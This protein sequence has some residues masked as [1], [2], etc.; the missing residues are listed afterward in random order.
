MLLITIDTLRADHVGCYGDRRVQTP[1]MDALASSGVRFESAFSQV[2]ITLP[3]HVAILTGTY[4][5]WNGV[6][7][8]TS[9]PLNPNVGLLAEAFKRQGYLTAAFVS[10]FVLD[11]SWGLNRGFETYD[12]HFEAKQFETRN[13]GDIQRRGDETVDRLLEWMRANAT[14]SAPKRPFFVWLHLYDPHSPYDPPEPY[15]SRFAG[16]LYDGEVAFADAQLGRLFEYLQKTGLYDRTLIVLLSDHGESLGDHGEA[17]HGF[18]IYNSTLHVPLIIKPPRGAAPPHTI[19]EPVATVDVAPTLLDLAGI[20]DPLSRQFQGASLA[21]SVLSKTSPPARPIYAETTYPR[22]SF[23][24]SDLHSVSTDHYHY[25]EAPHAELYEWPKDSAE[26]KNLLAG[27]AAVGAELRSQLLNLERRYAAPSGAAAA[28]PPLSAETVEKLKSL[29][30]LAYSPPAAASASGPL[31]DPKDK[32]KVLKMILRAEDL[33]ARGRFDESNTLLKSV[34]LEEPKLYLVPFMQAENSA[35]T[36][37]W[38]SAE[39]NFLASL[40]LNPTFEQAIMGIARAYLNDGKPR[41]ARPWL[42]LSLHQNPHN[43]LAYYAL[44]LAARQEH[45][46]DEALRHF[47]RAVEEKQDYAPAEAELGVLLVEMR[48][49]SDALAPLKI[50]AQYD[51]QNPV[52]LNF[53]GTSYSNTNQLTQ[54]VQSYQSALKIKPDYSAARLN[55]AFAYK[56][57][58]ESVKARQEF[59]TVCAQ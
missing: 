6:H 53:L 56:K 27:S 46:N 25:I 23:G 16:H 12:D 28:G 17:E 11:S 49:Y 51:P 58:G 34:A 32:L 59:K 50:A 41:D 10:A 44:G 19:R 40:K 15:H 52:V 2:P 31:P 5:M 20:R 1:S 54:A 43:F 9:Q 30:Y 38:A 36:R 7:D 8:F 24:W 18:F 21:S 45:Q 47:S 33:S 57:S 26:V 55:L 3:S 35:H 14:G 13:P 4:P 37:D 48:R 39:Q 29:G 22:D 42:E